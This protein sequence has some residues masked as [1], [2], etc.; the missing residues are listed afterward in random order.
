ME[1]QG[2]PLDI[3]D[4]FSWHFGEKKLTYTKILQV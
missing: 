2:I 4:D 1:N 3:G